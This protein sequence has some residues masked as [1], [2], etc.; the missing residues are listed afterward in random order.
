MKKKLIVPIVFDLL[1]YHIE[2]P[3][4]S[5][6]FEMYTNYCIN[7][8]MPIIAQEDYFNQEIFVLDKYYKKHRG[9][10]KKKEE[11]NED[12]KAFK[13]YSITNEETLSITNSKK[14]TFE[15][16][17]HFMSHTNTKY[18]KFINEKLDLIEKDYKQKVDAIFTWYWN[19]TLEEIGEKRDIKIITQEISPIREFNGNYRTRLSYF[20]FGNKFDNDNTE[21]LYKELKNDKEFSS[22]KIFSREELLAILLNTEDLNLIKELQKPT[23]YE[24]GISPPVEDDFFFEVYKNETTEKTFK[25]TD[26]LFNPKDVTIRYRIPFARDM[27]NPL[28]DR[29][30]KEKAIYWILQCKRILT[31]VSNIA[32]D[33]MLFGK[34]VYLLSDNMP[35]SFKSIT[36]LKYKDESVVDTEYLNFM[37]FGYFVPWDLM[38]DQEYI[39][40]R[41][42]NPSAI[43][44]YRKHQDH[45]F[46][47]LAINGSKGIT[48]EEIL[49]TNHHLEEKEARDI[50]EYSEFSSLEGL[51]E[52]IIIAKE[53]KQELQNQNTELQRQKVELQNQKEELIPDALEFREFKQTKI[54]KGLTMYRKL[55]KYTKNFFN[56]ERE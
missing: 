51:K 32:F 11:L 10:Q 16:Q 7:N 9:N 35:F 45:T 30:E 19:P 18:E 14:A 39:E 33:A 21:K 15:E 27:G 41:L 3:A 56:K 22:L 25:K 54:W 42:T 2:K 53:E 44:I 29:D 52:E 5:W 31:Y 43:D 36:Q 13:K 8:N 4:L 46:K 17:V 49:K 20:V 24:L 47:I 40:W 26:K 1:D 38:L 50:L 12:K 48:L 34:T 55:K 28:W 23:K 6:V 37:I